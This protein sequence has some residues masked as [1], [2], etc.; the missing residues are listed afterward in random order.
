MH[1]SMRLY[2]MVVLILL[3]F[4]YMIQ[5]IDIND[6]TN[7][8]LTSAALLFSVSSTF[9]TF[10][11]GNCVEKWIRNILNV[12][13]LMVAITIPLVKNTEFVKSIM[14]VFNTNVLL[15]LA[16]FFTLANQW[17]LEIKIKDIK[18]EKG[19]NKDGGYT[20]NNK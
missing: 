10:G 12:A 19:M 18:R 17:A 5:I 13:A 20:E 2:V 9:D 16:I 8:S 6:V 11:K 14:N 4:L 7:F 3:T 1:N 15:L